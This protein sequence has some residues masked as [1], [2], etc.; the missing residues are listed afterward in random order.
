M[1]AIITMITVVKHAHNNCFGSSTCS[2]H[3][4]FWVL[5][6]HLPKLNIIVLKEGYLHLAVIS[7]ATVSVAINTSC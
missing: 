5:I 7:S 1:Q 6:M 3:T 2:T 4:S